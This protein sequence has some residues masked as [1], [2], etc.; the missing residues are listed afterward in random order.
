MKEITDGLLLSYPLNRWL[1]ILQ[2]SFCLMSLIV[3]VILCLAFFFFLLFILDLCLRTYPA[4]E[5]TGFSVLTIRQCNVFWRSSVFKV[6]IIVFRGSHFYQNVVP[7]KRY[8]DFVRLI[9]NTLTYLSFSTATEKGKILILS[10]LVAVNL[11]D[12]GPSSIATSK[13][14]NVT[15][16]RSKHRINVKR[17]QL[18]L[19]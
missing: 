16:N 17:N 7:M 14:T 5:F 19:V 15:K 11:H 6:I 4:R 10:Y 9:F 18:T 8:I 12:H 13:I 2:T 3:R 1:I